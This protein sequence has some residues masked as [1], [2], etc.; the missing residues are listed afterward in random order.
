MA[1]IAFTHYGA[2]IASSVR[3]W[4][5]DTIRSMLV[6]TA[7]D[8]I[9]GED[10]IGD[11]GTLDECDSGNYTGGYQGASRPSPT[12][13]LAETGT[14]LVDFD[15][16]ATSETFTNL[17]ADNTTDIQGLFFIQEL[18]SEAVSRNVAFCDFGTAVA[19]TGQ[20]F[21]VNLNGGAD[22]TVMQWDFT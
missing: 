10:T 2:D 1:S 13:A 8:G 3:G 7:F 14:T 20:D 16:G 12:T 18:G 9:V 6:M 5:S 22:D 15:N 11:I 17:A 4:V 19:T 21:I